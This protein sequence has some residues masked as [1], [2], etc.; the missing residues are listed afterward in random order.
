M[1]GKDGCVEASGFFKTI[2]VS[3]MKIANDL[4]LLASGPRTGI[5]EIEIPAA[6]PGSSAMPGKV[7]PVIPEAVT[8]VAAKVVGND[9]SITTCGSV[10]QFELNILSPV[11]A[12]EPLEH[13]VL[14]SP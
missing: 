13:I 12:Y 7:N 5:S 8:L 9:T 1:Q 11:I 10:G 4:R 14:T 3:L 2:A 6:Q